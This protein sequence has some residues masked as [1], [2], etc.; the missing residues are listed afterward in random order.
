MRKLATAAAALA[1][2]I[3]VLGACGS[4]SSSASKSKT[5]TAPASVPVQLTGKV[6]DKGTK[7][8]SGKSTVEV[9]AD[10]YYFNPTF[11]KAT[12]GATLD[13]SLKNEGKQ[14]HTFTI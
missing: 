3:L 6:T 9:E 13:V 11:L 2:G 10:D 12:P 7:D 4:G 5:T 1:A 8:V 14:V